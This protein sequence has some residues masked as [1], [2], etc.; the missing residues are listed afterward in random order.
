MAPESSSP[1]RFTPLQ[2]ATRSRRVLVFVLGP[3]LWCA[4]LVFVSVIV[5]RTRA[6]EVGLLVT[7]VAFVLSFCVSIVARRRRLAEEQEA[8]RS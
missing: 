1:V 8:Q 2:T 4:A 3:L 6:I 5:N 7:L